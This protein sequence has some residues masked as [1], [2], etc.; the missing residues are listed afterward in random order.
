MVDFRSLNENIENSMDQILLGPLQAIRKKAGNDGYEAYDTSV[1]GPTGPIGATGYTGYT[2][3]SGTSGTGTS[4][5]RYLPVVTA[6]TVES[7]TT[8]SATLSPALTSYVD[9]DMF[10]FRIPESN[11]G[12]EIYLNINELGPIALAVMGIGG[13]INAS[14]LEIDYMVLL[15]Y[16]AKTSPCFQVLSTIII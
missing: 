4:I 6:S 16:N 15:A 9:G 10:L 8:Y 7:V 2:G 1:T 13:F 14:A 11:G 5:L 3:P 12:A